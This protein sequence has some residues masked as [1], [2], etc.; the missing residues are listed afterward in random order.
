M[1]GTTPS[2]D[3]FAQSSSLLDSGASG[4]LVEQSPLADPSIVSSLAARSSFSLGLDEDD[5]FFDAITSGYFTVGST[6]QVSIDYLFDGGGYEGELAIFSLSGLEEFVTDLSTLT[7]EIVRRALSDTVQGYV[8]IRDAIDRARFDGELGEASY[9]AGLPYDVKTFSM[10]AGDRFGLM[11]TPNGTIAALQNNPN[12]QGVD[13]P[14]F[15]L[16]GLNP[17]FGFQVGQMAD[18]D[19]S[20]STF[21][22]E[23]LRVDGESDRDYNDVIFRVS[24]AIGS[25]V[26]LDEVIDPAKNWRG[27]EVGQQLYGFIN[28]KDPD[29]LDSRLPRPMP[30]DYLPGS[31][32]ETAGSLTV[33]SFGRSYA[34]ILNNAGDSQYHRFSI[35]SDSTFSLSLEGLNSTAVEVLDSNGKVLLQT[36]LSGQS[37]TTLEQLLEAGTYYIKVTGGADSTPYKLI[38][39][40]QSVIDGLTTGGSDAPAFLTDEPTPTDGGG[41]ITPQSNPSARSLIGIDK[42]RADSRFAGIDGR[43]FTTVILDSGIALNHPFFGPDND[44]NGIADRIVYQYDYADGDPNASDVDGHGSNV[45]SIAVSSDGTYTGMAPG[46]N[47][48]HL[49]VF[50]NSGD[51]NFSYVENALKWVVANAEKYSIASVNLSIGDGTN[52]NT[53]QSLYG[54]SDEF[55]ALVA[56]NIIPVASAGNSFFGYQQQGVGGLAADP[57]ALAVGAVYDANYGGQA[58]KSGAID[59]STGA[60][61]ITSFSQRSTT[62]TDIFAPGGVVA[63]AAPGGGKIFMSGTSQ[64]APH[65]TGIATLMQQL[66]VQELGR[67]LTFSEFTSLLKSTGATIYDGDDENDNVTNTNQSYKRVDVYALAQAVLALKPKPK[68]A[69]SLSI[70]DANA[71]ETKW[72]ATPNPGRFTLSRAGGDNTKPETVYYSVSGSA[73][74]GSDY[75]AL[76]GY[77]TIPAGQT[78]VNVPINVIDDA[79]VENPENVTINLSSSSNYSL[80]SS[81]S[82]TVLIYDND[83]PTKSTISLSTSD[84]YA[85]ETSPSATPNPGKFTVTRAGGNNS[86][87]ETVYYSVTGTAANGGDYNY[88]SGSATIS[89]GQTS[90]DIP[91]NVFNDS[92][93]EATE[94]VNVSLYSN[95]SYNLS[96]ST[97][98]TVWIYDNDSPPVT[99]SVP[100]SNPFFNSGIDVKIG[101]KLTISSSGLVKYGYG[102]FE[103]SL[104]VDSNGERYSENGSFLFGKKNDPNAV[105]SGAIGAL[106]GKIGINGTPFLIG[107]SNQIPATT[108]GRLYLAINDTPG[109]YG[110][111]SGQFTVKVAV[112]R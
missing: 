3:L 23:D 76:S 83:V 7:Q 106:I 70:T 37:S 36:F 102:G 49:K 100:A 59:S 5:R 89:A 18:V 52:Y 19:G 28:Q 51:G 95:S 64:A 43:G 74:N 61:R 34:G 78:S 41:T 110:D 42:F 94:F 26:S 31:T 97:T 77:A 87:A 57:N 58:Y 82:G 17:E 90:V 71:S 65:I 104:L 62:L 85:S 98:G 60:D 47:I 20:G 4:Y 86:K 109:T 24:G 2:I 40:V 68:S 108:S 101:E 105:V 35:G 15:S 32:Q 48:I 67:R 92:L 55:A 45:S 79:I 22:L 84:W 16:V 33:S 88:L 63:G 111:N 69:I 9:N 99:V 81:T 13:R 54:I 103:G 21:V 91:I 12:P 66:A 56:K 25:A 112:G 73:T 50:P 1:P 14:L 96:S 72:G 39:S 46:S 107:A 29:S 27:L 80:G 10:T 6:G 8:V 93:Y 38:A 30:P 44:K 53:N 11:L 75:N